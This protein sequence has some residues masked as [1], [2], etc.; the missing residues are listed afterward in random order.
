MNG[1]NMM[2]I[3]KAFGSHAPGGFIVCRADGDE[4]ILY[5]N[6]TA[7][8][9]FECDSVEE[10]FLYTNGRTRGT[11]APE[12]YNREVCGAEALSRWNDPV[13]GSISPAVFIPA[14]EEA[15]LIHLLDSFVVG[16]VCQTVRERMDHGEAPQTAHGS[17]W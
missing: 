7:V 1:K 15:H 14:L 11:V 6:D 12:E 17:G 8:H 10:F 3:F 4:E 16:Q 2:E 5:A 13:H 9:L